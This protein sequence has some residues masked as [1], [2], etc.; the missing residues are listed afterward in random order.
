MDK[1]TSC[2]K[3]NDINAGAYSSDKEKREGMKGAM[4]QSDTVSDDLDKSILELR[5]AHE[6]CREP[7][8]MPSVVWLLSPSIKM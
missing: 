5:A 3:F 6:K 7:I 4:E 1:N 2:G 8:S